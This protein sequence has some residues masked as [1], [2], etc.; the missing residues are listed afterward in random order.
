MTTPGLSSRIKPS[1]TSSTS[2]AAKPT[3]YYGKQPPIVTKSNSNGE[4]GQDAI[5]SFSR[6]STSSHGRFNMG[7]IIAM[8]IF[9]SFIFLAAILTI[10]IIV[11]RR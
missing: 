5:N 10:I 9:G 11:F 4:K 1:T 7:G 6:K 3:G 2:H 8:A